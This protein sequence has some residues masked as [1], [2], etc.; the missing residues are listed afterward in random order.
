MC[1]CV[2]EVTTCMTYWIFIM[3]HNNTPA[4]TCGVGV[5]TATVYSYSILKSGFGSEPSCHLSVG[6]MAYLDQTAASRDRLGG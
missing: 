6:V 2:Y 3:P 1:V 5:I 4:E